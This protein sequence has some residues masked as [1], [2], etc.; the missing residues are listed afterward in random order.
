[1]TTYTAIAN[2]EIDADSPVTT[3]LMQAMRDNPIAISEGSSGAPVVAAGWHPYDMVTVGDGNDGAIYDSAVDGSVATVATPSFADGY[4]YAIVFEQLG[5]IS[6]NTIDARIYF[7]VAAGY[8]AWTTISAL[9]NL[10]VAASQPSGIFYLPMSRV[11]KHIHEFRWMVDLANQTTGSVSVAASVTTGALDHAGGI[12][13][14]ASGSNIS[15]GKIKL[16][17]RREY[18]TG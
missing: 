17:R 7:D 6:T 16:L 14:R 13:L 2:S 10:G 4:E 9:I 5:A 1:M 11:L 18:L 3:T 8:S 15:A 12:E